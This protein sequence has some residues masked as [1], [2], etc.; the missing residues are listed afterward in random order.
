[1]ES[2]K[3]LEKLTDRIKETPEEI[4]KMLVEST[5]GFIKKMAELLLENEVNEKVGKRYERNSDYSR[6]GT[7]PGSIRIDEEKVMIAV[8]RIKDRKSDRV[9]Q[10]MRR[11][12]VG[13]VEQR[14]QKGNI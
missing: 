4:E 12:I 3:I 14:G 7:N 2:N 6:W 8:P 5:V 11:Y 1:M 9:G 13:Y 10:R